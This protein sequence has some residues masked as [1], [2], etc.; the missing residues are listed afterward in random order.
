MYVRAATA[1]DAKHKWRPSCFLLNHGGGTLG[2]IKSPVCNYDQNK[3]N[4]IYIYICIQSWTSVGFAYY[5]NLMYFSFLS[6]RSGRRGPPAER[7]A[8]YYIP[9]R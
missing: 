9:V 3:K 6:E 2:F 4:Y 5:S 8:L 1:G 7:S